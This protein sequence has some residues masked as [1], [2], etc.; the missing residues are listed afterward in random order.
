M[1]KRLRIVKTTKAAP[2]VGGASGGRV[3]QRQFE[4]VGE[5]GLFGR[6]AF[7][8]RLL[9]Y[10]IEDGTLRSD[11]HQPSLSRI[12][13]SKTSAALAAGFRTVRAS[14]IRMF[15]MAAIR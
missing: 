6:S 12:A 11:K 10:V 13:F 2:I 7:A 4:G 15:C 3:A 8:T 1:P 14:K 9:S 5:R